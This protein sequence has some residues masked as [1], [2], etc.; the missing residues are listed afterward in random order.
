MVPRK[1]KATVKQHYVSAGYLSGFTLGGTRHSSFWVH[2]L[3]GGTPREDI[4]DHVGFER[5]YH[6]I[7]HPGFKPDHLEYEFAKFEGPA[8]ELFKK[9]SATPGYTLSSSEK[10]IALI[11]FV[12]QAAR[13]PLA[14]EKYKK[15]LVDSANKQLDALANNKKY[16]EMAMSVAK[17]HGV[18]T[19]TL[20]QSELRAAVDSGDIFPKIE[21]TQLSAGIPRL[22]ESISEQLEGFHYTLLYSDAPDTFVC[23]DYPVGIFYSLSAGDVLENPASVEH[24]VVHLETNTM[25][26]PLAYNVALMVHRFDKNP[27]AL[28]ADRGMVAVVNS[29]AISHAQRFVCSPTPD[30]SCLLPGGRL[31]NAREGIE[32]VMSMNAADCQKVRA[33]PEPYL[34]RARQKEVQE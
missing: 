32:T 19:D 1:Q 28:R 23:S 15:L 17:R 11:F 31:G 24:P 33:A 8:C 7:I 3:D 14:K 22:A 9:L 6:D 10:S 12:L 25:Y 34:D 13:V 4:P 30:F 20:S 29:I 5:H 26:M 2:P 16:F 21:G 18:D 27:I